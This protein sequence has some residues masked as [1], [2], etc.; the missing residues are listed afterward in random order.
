MTKAKLTKLLK[1]C[2]KSELT[3]I[4]LKASERNVF[5]SWDS[6]ISEIKLSEIDKKIDANLE[7]FTALIAR[8]ESLPKEKRVIGNDEAR[9]LQIE[10]NNN[11]LK[12]RRLND[13][14]DKIEKKLY[15]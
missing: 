3:E 2:S 4:I 14:R 1:T 15:E 9:N 8:I 12:Y 7:E 11:L 6:I 5:F 13:R 10:I